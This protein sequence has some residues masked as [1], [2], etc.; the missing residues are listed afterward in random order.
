MSQRESP[1]GDR[2]QQLRVGRASR[3]HL[4]LLC[5]QQRKY[6]FHWQVNLLAEFPVPCPSPPFLFGQPSHRSPFSPAKRHLCSL[7]SRSPWWA[8]YCFPDLVS[9]PSLYLLCLLFPKLV[10]RNFPCSQGDCGKGVERPSALRRF[11]RLSQMVVSQLSQQNCMLLLEG[12]H[13]PPCFLLPK[14][15]YPLLSPSSAPRCMVLPFLL[16]QLQLSSASLARTYAISI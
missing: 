1:C 14:H 15:S 8:G 10:M 5:C 6:L 13:L 12:G 9:P 4:K 7:G 3:N 2:N 16:H 11:Y